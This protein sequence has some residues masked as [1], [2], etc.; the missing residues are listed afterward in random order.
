MS[1]TLQEAATL[2]RGDVVVFAHHAL[3]VQGVARGGYALWLYDDTHGCA[4]HIRM[5]P[6]NMG[7]LRLL[8]RA[9]EVPPD[10]RC[11]RYCEGA[12]TNL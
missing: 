5:T 12:P 8:Y 4:H 11:S 3:I 9:A 7:D 2:H 1:M 10:W 6:I